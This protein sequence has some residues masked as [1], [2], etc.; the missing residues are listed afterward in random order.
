V[1]EAEKQMNVVIIKNSLSDRDITYV[2]E[3]IC[4]KNYHVENML[5]MQ[6]INQ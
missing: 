1:Y 4:T 6:V 5:K 3:V 2:L